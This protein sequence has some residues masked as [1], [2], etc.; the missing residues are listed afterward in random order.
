MADPR[1]PNVRIRLKHPLWL[2]VLH[3]VQTPVLLIMLWSGFLIYWANDIYWPPIPQRLY[4]KL[5][6]EQRLA[7]GMAYH[8]T[9]AWPFVLCGFLYVVLLA[10]AGRWRE[11]M[12]DR[13]T[14]RDAFFVVLHDFGLRQNLPKQGRFNA[15]QKLA[16][17]SVLTMAA[18]A[19][20][21]GIAIYKPVQLSWLKNSM[22]GYE[23]ARWLHYWIAIGFLLFLLVHVV[24]VIRAGWNTFRS[25]ITGFE[26][27]DE[28]RT[29]H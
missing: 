7:E 24:Q 21:T 29:S 3:W 18:L 6:V 8:F 10:V 26:A 16:Y 1:S 17:L 5:N 11:F 15:A 9:F 4:E 13:K 22:G 2:R 23:L 25:M 19:T 12:I 20:I 28:D 27:V 14:L